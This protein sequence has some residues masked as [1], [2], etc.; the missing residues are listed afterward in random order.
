MR[1]PIIGT[2]PDSSAVRI[3]TERLIGTRMLVQANSGGGKSYMLRKLCE[4]LGGTTPIIFLDWE[5]EFASLREKLDVLLVGQGRELPTALA[6]AGALASQILEIGVSAVIDLYDLK[7]QDKRAYVR[8]FIESMMS[9]PKRLWRPYFVFVDEAHL[10]VPEH[11]DAESADAVNALMCQGRKRQF[12]GILATQRLSK[13]HKD[14]AAEA[15]NCLIGRCALDLDQKRAGD[16]LGMNKSEYVRLR[17]LTEGQFYGFGPAF[18]FTG[19][20]L[21]KGSEVETTH[22]HKKG[23]EAK[24]P[25]PSARMQKAISQLADLAERSKTEVLDMD[26]ARLTIR[27]LRQKVSKLEKAP[28]AP[29][30]P[31]GL[32]DRL[33]A[34]A[35]A[36]GAKLLRDASAENKGLRAALEKAGTTIQAALRREDMADKIVGYAQT[37]VTLAAPKPRLIPVPMTNGHAEPPEG[38]TPRHA[39]VL[40]AIRL[41]HAM[42]YEQPT[43]ERVSFWS[44]KRGGNF[45]NLLGALRTAGEIDYPTSGTVRATKEGDTPDPAEAYQRALA[46]IEGRHRAILDAIIEAGGPVERE[47]LSATTGK[48]GGNFNNLLGS[49][50]TAGLIV[51]PSQGMVDAAPWLRECA[52]CP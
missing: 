48:S 17:E 34:I 49:L 16:V 26:S 36:E 50:R 40:T 6:T 4:T 46:A 43:R 7:I 13:L 52:A 44:R 29:A 32:T 33:I 28:Q 11:G 5:G 18:N 21:F 2:E 10:L 14:A 19:V 41:C 15:N 35:K 39:D 22:G 8:R 24:P 23:V 31:P 38:L 20:R 37:T 30:S 12:C 3:D 27:D 1:H 47:A 45:N 9:A 51:Y 25:E 42:G